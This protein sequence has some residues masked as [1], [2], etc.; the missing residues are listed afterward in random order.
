[1]IGTQVRGTVWYVR[2]THRVLG[3]AAG[4]PENAVGDGHFI[5]ADP[6]GSDL[7]EIVRGAVLNGKATDA[8]EFTLAHVNRCTD[9]KGTAIAA[10]GA[11]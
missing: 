8:H 6:T 9:V 5:T 3:A 7:Y 1:M 4:Q 11:N 2:W 10:G